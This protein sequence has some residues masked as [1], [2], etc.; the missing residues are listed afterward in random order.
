MKG[1]EV[2]WKEFVLSEARTSNYGGLPLDKDRK[3]VRRKKREDREK[4]KKMAGV[5]PG[6]VF[7]GDDLLNT[8]A[9][10]NEDDKK[11][12]CTPGNP[13]HRGSDPSS[14]P[15]G[16]FASKDEPGSWS[17]ATG[18]S[19]TN[20]EKGKLQ[21]LGGKRTRWTK[22]GKGKSGCGRDGQF[23]CSNPK[24][25][26]WASE[27]DVSEMLIAFVDTL[28]EEDGM[29]LDEQGQDCSACIQNYLKSLNAAINASKGSL[30]KTGGKK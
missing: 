5:G 7:P 10:Y 16:S 6:Q 29:L 24:V 20:C 18:D 28:L 8:N 22:A 23:L 1:F 15:P 3:S 4:S 21:K 2:I 27:D 13:N 25:K 14:G 30:F 26:K 17:L 11:K 12:N 9:L 19:S